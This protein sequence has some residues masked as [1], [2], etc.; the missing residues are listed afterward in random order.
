M[1]GKV[2]RNVRCVGIPVGITVG[3]SVGKDVG[4][5][6]GTNVGR[7]DGFVDGM[8]VGMLEEL[9]VG[10]VGMR[11]TVVDGYLVRVSIEFYLVL[12]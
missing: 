10:L 8:I 11:D 7:L 4:S 9:S 12:S 2:G 5:K 3:M 6:D 1:I